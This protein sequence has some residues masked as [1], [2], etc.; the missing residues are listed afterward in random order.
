MTPI[1]IIQKIECNKH[2]LTMRLRRMVLDPISYMDKTGAS[3]PQ[4][5][6]SVNQKHFDVLL[7]AKSIMDFYGSKWNNPQSNEEQ[8]LQEL[9]LGIDKLNSEIIPQ[10]KSEIVEFYRLCIAEPV[11]FGQTKF[12]VKARQLMAESITN[13]D[14]ICDSLIKLDSILPKQYINNQVYNLLEIIQGVMD[15]LN[16]VVDYPDSES[17]LGYYV[18]IDLKDFRE[19]VLENIRN[20][21]E[22]HA[23]GTKQFRKVPLY[24]RHVKIE[25]LEKELYYIVKIYNNG[26]PYMG[27]IKRVFEYGYKYGEQEHTGIGMYNIKKTMNDLGGDVMFYSFSDDMKLEYKTVYELKI[28]K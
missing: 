7:K 11:F 25:I 4:Y 24:N 23:F 1:E 13:C 5:R 15:G 2:D 6:E 9:K 21:I 27:D 16:A 26:I 14:E 20:N 18:S 10:I 3:T 12:G 17:S 8:Q 19:H 28:K 22:L